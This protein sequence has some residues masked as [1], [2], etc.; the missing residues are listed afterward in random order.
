MNEPII[1]TPDEFFA[2]RPQKYDAWIDDRNLPSR[3]MCYFGITALALA[4]VVRSMLYPFETSYRICTKAQPPHQREVQSDIPT[5]SSQIKHNPAQ[6]SNT[7]SEWSMCCIVNL[8]STAPDRGEIIEML[9]LSY[10]L[11]FGIEF[12]LNAN[13]RVE[14]IHVF[15]GTLPQGYT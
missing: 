2:N 13:D 11:T 4:L 3:G 15:S 5:G 14:H 1:F 12:S 8:K 6:T 9:H 7:A 10:D